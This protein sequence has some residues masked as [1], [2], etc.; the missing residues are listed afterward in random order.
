[1]KSYNKCVKFN[2]RN[3]AL[4]ILECCRSKLTLWLRNAKL[5]LTF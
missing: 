5:F 2:N 1:M 4:L 3:L